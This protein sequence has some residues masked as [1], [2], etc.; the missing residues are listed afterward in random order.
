MGMGMASGKGKEKR[1][2]QGTRPG[3]K[4]GER[5][6]GGRNKFINQSVD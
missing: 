1:K 3:T 6:A 2:R 5:F 4:T